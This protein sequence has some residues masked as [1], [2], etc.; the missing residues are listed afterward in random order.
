MLLVL[1]TPREAVAR[2]LPGRRPSQNQSPSAIN[3][4]SLLHKE[5]RMTPDPSPS[6]D[7]IVPL[8]GVGSHIG[9]T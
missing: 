6:S 7:R 9:T 2:K 8:S 1:A 5:L 4:L 3:Y